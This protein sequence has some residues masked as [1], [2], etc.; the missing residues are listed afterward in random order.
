MREGTM[1]TNVTVYLPTT[2]G[3]MVVLG[4][5]VLAIGGRISVTSPMQSARPTT[6]RSRTPWTRWARQ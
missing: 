5:E 3:R 4:S 1:Q 6:Y 2:P